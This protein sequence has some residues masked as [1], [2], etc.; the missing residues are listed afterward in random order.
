MG[1]VV[2]SRNPKGRIQWVASFAH[3]ATAKRFVDSNNRIY[4][5]HLEFF[6]EGKRS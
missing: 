6:I 4:K 2:N 3:E 1:I 5:G